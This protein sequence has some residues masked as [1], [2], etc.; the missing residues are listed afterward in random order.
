MVD[1]S[2][3][4]RIYDRINRQLPEWILQ[5]LRKTAE[6]LA[7]EEPFANDH[8]VLAVMPNRPGAPRCA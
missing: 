4:L 3:G 5:V 1:R 7:G 8:A 6:G 2:E